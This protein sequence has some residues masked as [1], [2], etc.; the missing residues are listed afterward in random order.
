MKR[1]DLLHGTHNLNVHYDFDDVDDDDDHVDDL[2]HTSTSDLK[3]E[4]KGN[5]LLLPQPH[6]NHTNGNEKDD[7]VTVGT[8]MTALSNKQSQ[9]VNDA[10]TPSTAV[11]TSHITNNNCHH[12]SSHNHTSHSSSMTTAGTISLQ[13]YLERSPSSHVVPAVNDVRSTRTTTT[14]TTMVPTR[15]SS[16]TMNNKATAATTTT[17]NESVTSSTMDNTSWNDDDENEESCSSNHL[18]VL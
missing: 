18:V 8:T 1:I 17:T 14:T 11:N 4:D 7:V 9:H 3:E 10:V 2:D 15:T 6:P 16:F 13:A 5:D 12:Q